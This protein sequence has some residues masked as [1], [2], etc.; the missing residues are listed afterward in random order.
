MPAR[1]KHSSTRRRTNKSTTA[2]TLR[3]VPEGERATD[4]YRAMTVPQLRSEIERRNQ[5]RHREDWLSARG[6][7]AQLVQRLL[8]D[9][10]TT[11]QLPTIADGWHP[12]TLRW[13]ADIWAS[14]MSEEWDDSDIHNVFV[15][16][17]VYNDIWTASSPTAR[18]EAASEFR[19]QRANLGLTPYDRRRLEWTIE[20]ADEA[21]DRGNQRRSKRTTPKPQAEQQKKAADPRAA[22]HAVK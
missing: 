21:R 19:L 12:M 16:A 7:K 20:T 17:A 9:D 1:K 22:L 4:Q 15:L 13:W 2:A 6:V 5:G 10:D 14:P 18:K 3:R 8:E 11:P